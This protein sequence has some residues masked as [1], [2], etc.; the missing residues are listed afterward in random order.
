MVLRANRLDGVNECLH[1]ACVASRVG[2]GA[3]QEGWYL[4]RVINGRCP[5]II[6]NVKAEKCFSGPVR[7][8]RQC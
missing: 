5:L 4:V 6:V 3:A 2:R 7:H 8:G 1:V